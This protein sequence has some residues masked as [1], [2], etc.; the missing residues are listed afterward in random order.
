MNGRLQSRKPQTMF[1]LIGNGTVDSR[2]AAVLTVG[3]N[4]GLCLLFVA[5]PRFVGKTTLINCMNCDYLV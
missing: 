2:M 1:D 4:L 3:A 5:M